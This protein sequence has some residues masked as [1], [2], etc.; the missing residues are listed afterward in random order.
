MFNRK[1]HNEDFN[2][3]IKFR[4]KPTPIRNAVLVFSLT[5]N[6]FLAAGGYAIAAGKLTPASNL[7][8]VLHEQEDFVTTL[9]K[10]K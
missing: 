5:C 3:I 2:T 7:E 10:R 6:L 9:A 4:K 1:K 8:V